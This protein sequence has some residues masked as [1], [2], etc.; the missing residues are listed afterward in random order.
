MLTLCH[1]W[2][3][4]LDPETAGSRRAEN[5]ICWFRR[6]IWIATGDFPLAIFSIASFVTIFVVGIIWATRPERKQDSNR[7]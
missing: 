3:S 4:P 6:F 7:H 2:R 1:G 5:A